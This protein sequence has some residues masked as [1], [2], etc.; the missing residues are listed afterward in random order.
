MSR[1]PVSRGQGA[2]G[3]QAQVSGGQAH[4]RTSV[5]SRAMSILA[6]FDARYPRLTL[7][8]ITSRAGLAHATAYR[9]TQELVEWGALVRKEDGTY[10]IGLRL[11]EIGTLAPQSVPLRDLA[12]PVMEDLYVAI[13]QHIQLAVRQGSEALVIERISAPKSIQLMSGVGRRLPLHASAAG[14]ILLAHSEPELLEE[15]MARPLRRYTPATITDPTELRAVL[16]GCR[17]SGIAVVRGGL[18]L[19]VQSVA[20]RITDSQGKVVAALSVVVREGSAEARAVI[21]AAVTAGLNISRRIR[22]VERLSGFRVSG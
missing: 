8:Q 1:R 16:A 2:A 3:A 6:A 20:T 22:D 4:G 7:A 15:L 10:C 5:T 21:P 12:M 9:L 14:Q 18:T 11:W 17:G 19:G 13:N